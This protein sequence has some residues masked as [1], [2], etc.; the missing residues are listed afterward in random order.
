[1]SDR[2]Q[3]NASQPGMPGLSMMS[4]LISAYASAWGR[5]IQALND[6]WAGAT[7]ADAAV[8]EWPKAWSRLAQAWS[9]SAQDICGVYMGHMGG[10]ACA[11][12]PFVTFV[13]DRSAETDAQPQTVPLPP[14]VDPTKL[15]ATAPVSL[16]QDGH[17]TLAAQLILLW[18]VDDRIEIRLRVPDP[19]PQPGPYLSVIYESKA[20]DPA[21]PITVPSNPPPRQVIATVLIVF[22]NSPI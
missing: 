8:S 21:K 14:G 18:P 16:A 20:G 7:S 4:D 6:A 5:H 11:G 2:D 1:M 10:S 22:L 9:A 3:R 13:I 12:S 19:A 17:P 15:V